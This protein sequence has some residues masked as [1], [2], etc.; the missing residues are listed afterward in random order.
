MRVWQPVF[1]A[2]ALL[3]VGCAKP[4]PEERAAAEPA[5]PAPPSGG[6]G[7]PDGVYNCGDGAR[8]LGKVDIQGATFRYRPQDATGGIFA[9]YAVTASGQIHWGGPFPGLEAPPGR[10]TTST[11]E[12][13]GF[14]VSYQ[15]TP[16]S[17]EQTMSCV[18]P[19]KS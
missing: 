13:T 8:V 11:R 7:L 14:N 19:A 10:V 5:A 12:A 15:P 6:G 3:V 16:E 1:V 4:A 9:P 2:L 18:G 17:A